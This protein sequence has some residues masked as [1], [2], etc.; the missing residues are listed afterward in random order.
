MFYSP[1]I[2]WAAVTVGCLVLEG[3][4][5]ALVCIWF[6]AGAAVALVLSLLGCEVW[7]QTVVFLAVSAAL[8]SLLRPMLRKYVK[9]TKTNVDSVIGAQGLVTADID[10]IR[11]TGQ[12][13]LGAMF[14]TA[15]SSDGRPIPTGTR[16]RADRVEGVKVYVSPA[17]VPNHVN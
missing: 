7:L 16:V 4:T 9:R 3:C 2:V 8:L 15:R 5:T 10:N 1:A 17:E 14:W 6:A 11:S 12:V 13:K